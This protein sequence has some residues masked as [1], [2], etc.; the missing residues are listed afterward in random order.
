M[1]DQRGV[2]ENA[3]SIPMADADNGVLPSY[4]LLI[5]NIILL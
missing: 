1:V 2:P 5:N 3:G 4:K